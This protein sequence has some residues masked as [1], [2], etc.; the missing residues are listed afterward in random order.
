MTQPTVYVETT[1]IG[2]L[3]GRM[4]ADPIVAGRQTL[5]RQWWPIAEKSYRLLV[6]QLV[7]DECSAGDPVAAAERLAV[8]NSMA[9]LEASEDANKLAGLLI[10]GL[11]I[12][13]TEPR[14]AG[15]IALAAVNGIEYLVTWNFK[16]IANPKTR[17]V[18]ESICQD[19]GYDSPIICTPDELSEE[20]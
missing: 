20:E 6:S 8:L 9:L 12:P 4:L 7:V 14:D 15:H 16:H 5:T 13:A 11:A 3:V 17:V 19:A 18:I 10:A 2:H 1:V